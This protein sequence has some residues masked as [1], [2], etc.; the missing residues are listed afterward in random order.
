MKT[1]LPGEFRTGNHSISNQAPYQLSYRNLVKNVENFLVLP[2][3]SDQYWLTLVFVSAISNRPGP[4]APPRANGASSK[5]K[6]KQFWSHSPFP[7]IL[8]SSSMNLGMPK[9][10]EKTRTGTRYI[11]TG[12]QL[13]LPFDTKAGSGLEED[14]LYLHF[15]KY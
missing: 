11:S 10:T 1:Y 8:I 3:T 6:L 4:F 14:E 9:A 15:L 7:E 12:F 5:K 13:L 2:Q